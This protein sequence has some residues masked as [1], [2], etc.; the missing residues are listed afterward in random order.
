MRSISN[1]DSI[2]RPN[3]TKVDSADEATASRWIDKLNDS[4]A[5][6][7]H[8]PGSVA[9][10]AMRLHFWYKLTS[11]RSPNRYIVVAD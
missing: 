3:R 9:H 1:P 5:R 11:A 6:P 7:R 4:F 8:E 10:H 2:F